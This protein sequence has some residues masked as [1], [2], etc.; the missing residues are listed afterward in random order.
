MEVPRPRQRCLL[1]AEG[2]LAQTVQLE[3]TA[4]E[5]DDITP[6]LLTSMRELHSR[7]NDDLYVRLL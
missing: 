3:P 7:V 1:M 4:A 5:S 6:G 2:E